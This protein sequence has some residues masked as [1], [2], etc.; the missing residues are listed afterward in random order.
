VTLELLEN[1]DEQLDAVDRA[2]KLE[3]KRAGRIDR[4]IGQITCLLRDVDSDSEHNSA[5]ARLGE[6]AGDLLPAEQ[7]VVRVLDRRLTAEQGNC[8]HDR[9]GGDG[10][11]G[12]EPG[13]LD[14]WPQAKREEQAFLRRSLPF[15]PPAPSSLR[16]L[17]GQRER[18]LGR[19]LGKQI[20]GGRAAR[21]VQVERHTEAPFQAR[22]DGYRRERY[23]HD[24]YT[25]S[26]VKPQ[27]ANR[28][29]IS[30]P[31]R[32]DSIIRYERLSDPILIKRAKD[33]DGKAL[34]TL[35]ERYADRVGRIARREL[36]DQRDA[37]DA[38][39]DSLLKL[40]QRIGQYRGE[41]QF[42][43]WLH[44]LV[45]NTCHD[46]AA[47][48]G[49]RRAAPLPDEFEL[50]RARDFDPVA[51]TLGA[52]LRAELSGHLSELP[53]EQARVVVLKD[54]LGFSFEQIAG[55]ARMPV[56]TAKCYAH[57]ARKRLRERLEKEAAA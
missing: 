17:L 23:G 48:E 39:Q 52:E 55:A 8:L 13:S 6:D 49:L 28:R 47:R 50:E 9:L 33:G 37:Q 20:L 41:A 53:V 42:A 30:S 24:L 12:C 11:E 10:G 57:R 43:T 56:G 3:Q 7:Y 46:T 36:S 14:L 40:C 51:E 21:C 54:A 34:E 25:S 4:P 35:C 5:T 32:A 15:A 38:A 29:R 1:A 31:L 22:P 2:S 44:R 19:A 18:A 45:V 16:L 26:A 27:G